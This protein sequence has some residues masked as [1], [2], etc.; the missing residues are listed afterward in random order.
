MYGKAQQAFTSSTCVHTIQFIRL[1]VGA[2]HS[3]ARPCQ[4]ALSPQPRERAGPPG[5]RSARPENK[6]ASALGLSPSFGPLFLSF[7]KGICFLTPL[8]RLKSKQL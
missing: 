7:P 5:R 8:K 1:D 4:V 6:R 2:S 3:S